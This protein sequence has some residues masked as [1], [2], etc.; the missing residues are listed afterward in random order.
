MRGI[1]Q[2][3]C[4]KEESCQESL[5]FVVVV[6]MCRV[7]WGIQLLFIIYDSQAV[8][9]MSIYV[10]ESLTW[11]RVEEL[12]VGRLHSTKTR[13]RRRCRKRKKRRAFFMITTFHTRSDIILELHW[14]LCIDYFSMAHGWEHFL[15]DSALCFS[16][17]WIF[18]CWTCITYVSES[19]KLLVSRKLH[20][21]RSDL[22]FSPFQLQIGNFIHCSRLSDGN[23]LIDLWPF[24]MGLRSWFHMTWHTWSIEE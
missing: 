22:H 16:P 5:A 23:I 24:R 2:N 19:V 9:M 15:H 3:K 7:G 11:W 18:T 20:C 21:T 14:D 17:P 6:C 10:R 8:L 13:T 12:N 4:P 1:H